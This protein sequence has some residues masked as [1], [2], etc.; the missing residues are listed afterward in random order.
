MLDATRFQQQIQFLTEID[1]LKQ[2]LRRTWLL[3]A[4]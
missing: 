3:A 4:S 1:K 2:V